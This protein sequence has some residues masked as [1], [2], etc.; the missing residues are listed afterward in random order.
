[1]K[2]KIRY[3]LFS[4]PLEEDWLTA[5]ILYGEEHIGDLVEWGEKLFLYPRE[6]GEFWKLPVDEFLETIKLAKERVRF[7]PKDH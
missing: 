7:I 4:G 1:M 2:D 3:Q 6:N 5:E